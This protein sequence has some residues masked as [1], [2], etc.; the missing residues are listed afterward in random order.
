MLLL[1]VFYKPIQAQRPFFNWV[2]CYQG[3]QEREAERQRYLDSLAAAGINLDVFTPFDP[4]EIVGS[5][6]YD[7]P[8]DTLQWVSVTASLPYTIYFENDPDF[9]TA[10]AQKVEI[11]MPLHAKAD[12]ATFAIG[13]F[14]F[15]SHIFAVENNLA[16]YQQRLDLS[17]DM[18]L[19]LDVVAGI[20]VVTNEAFWIFESI[21][22]ATGLPPQGTQQGFLPI[23]DES[24][25][26]EGFVS[27]TIKPKDSSCVTGDVV[28]ATASIVFDVNEPLSTNVWHNTVD[29]LPPMTYL[30]GS[31]GYDNEVLLQFAGSDDQGG[32]GIKQYK[33]YVSDNYASYALYDIY[34]AGEVAH[35]PT[36]FGHCY[37]FFCLG[38][39]NV[40]NVEEM[41]T[42]PDFEYGNYNLTV[43]ATAS[44]TEGG[45][46]SGMG[47]FPYNATV[48]LTASPNIGYEFVAWLNQGVQ[49][50]TNPTYSFTV[51]E[52]C[53][54]VATFLASS[55]TQTFP[56]TQGWNWW[57]TYVE[58][59]GIDGLTLLEEGLGTNG[60]IIKSQSD[61][62][63][64]YY[65]DYDL[66]YGSLE[67][68]N[69]ETYYMIK[70]SAPCTVSLSGPKAIPSLHPITVDAN[71]WTWISYPVSTDL[72]I[73]EALSGLASIEGDI[74]K[75][76]EGYAEFYEGY[77]WYGTLETLTPNIGLMYKSTSAYPQTFTYPEGGRT[78]LRE[79]PTSKNNHWV[80]DP[81]AY[82]YNMT[83][84]AIVELDDVELRSDRYE[85]AAFADDETR[86]S[87][88][89]HY[90][91][92]IDRYVAFLTITGE[93]AIDL[94]FGLYDNETGETY[95][96]L[97]NSIGFEAN[98][99]LGSL[100]KPYV[101]RF[102][103]LTGLDEL[104]N[105]LYVYPN[106]VSVGERFSIWLPMSER[107]PVRIEIVDAL[108][109]VLSVNTSTKLP[110]SIAAPITAGV[111][112][113]R[114]QVEGKGTYCRKLIVK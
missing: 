92:P 27:F 28:T 111:Y 31:E 53:A 74:I 46:V 75:A 66:W 88:K 19:Y 2:K 9:A 36:E 62:Y 47:T 4:N 90:I 97:D 40:G 29:A 102:G 105:S 61:G 110:V 5:T 43:T 42:E 25:N 87:V 32:C 41:K 33:L 96:A 104:T 78:A 85:L 52:N 109:S 10:T 21:D 38:E 44:P 80:P 45:T 55:I 73:N 35:F 114:I 49:V 34:P 63:T 91:E 7:A 77:G 12:I 100:K 1:A 30:T 15:G 48:T 3:Y 76:Q 54:L 107:I 14:G 16:A 84:T 67:S 37:R 11:R 89:L 83:V 20:D 108:G 79:N 99:A 24:H 70:A 6:G 69:N 68:I 106:P 64:E 39:D 56:L 17:E 95:L 57:S 94:Y 113:M 72:D 51:T 103:N 58:Q 26:G 112:T 65:D 23:N 18:G 60:L 71:G 8:G 98:T 101:V 50:S 59:S 82:P 22:P 86:G 93:E 81:S 13:S